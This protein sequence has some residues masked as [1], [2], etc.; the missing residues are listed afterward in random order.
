MTHFSKIGLATATLFAGLAIPNAAQADGFYISGFTGLAIQRDQNNTSGNQSL[1]I[2]LDNGF[3]I[4]GAVGYKLPISGFRVELEAAYRE[5]DVSAGQ[6]LADPT[7]SFNGDNSS[8][9]VFGNLLYDF[10]GLPLI[11]P[12]IGVGI[13]VGGVES[14]VFGSFDSVPGTP[15]PRFGGPTSTEFLYQGILGVTLP[16]T[17]TWDLF[18]DGRYYVAPGAEFDLIDVATNTRTTF[19]SNYEVIQ[20]QAGLRFKF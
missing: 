11:T 5:N 12:Y 8:L 7:A 14:D 10:E 17:D 4:G 1:D 2:S 16:L 20:L 3:V 6:F 18:V 15:D 9:G 19:D 13:G